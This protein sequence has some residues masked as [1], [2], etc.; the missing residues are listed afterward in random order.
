MDKDLTTGV[1]YPTE[2]RTFVFAIASREALGPTQSSIKW[3][4]GDLTGITGRSGN[5]V[6]H[7]RLLSKLD[8][9]GVVSPL[10]INACGEVFKLRYNFTLSLIIYR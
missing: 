7:V 4:P 10:P 1:L 3:M 8:I 2:A 5:L 6:T 9:G